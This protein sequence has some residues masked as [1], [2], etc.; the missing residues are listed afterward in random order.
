MSSVLKSEDAID[1]C[2]RLLKARLKGFAERNEE[3]DMRLWLELY[4]HDVIVHIFFGQTFGFLERGTD[5]DSFMESVYNAGPLLQITAVAPTYVR[6]IIM[7][8]AMCIPGTLKQ[9]RAVRATVVEAKRQTRL[10]L[11]RST[12]END[13]SQDIPSQL[14]RT[15]REKALK[16]G[17]YTKKSHWSLGLVSWP[18]QTPSP[19]TYGQSYIS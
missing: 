1:D 4:A 3:V 10:R 17:L 15:V 13:Q 14:L 5:R 11:Q 12:E 6:N 9:F 2:T 19:A 18:V 16:V 8:S 7:M